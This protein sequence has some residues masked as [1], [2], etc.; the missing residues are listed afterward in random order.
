[1]VHLHVTLGQAVGG[2]DLVLCC[3]VSGQILQ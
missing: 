3:R 1:M 2:R